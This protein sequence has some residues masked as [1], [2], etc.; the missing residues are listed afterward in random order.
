[1]DEGAGA[2]SIRATLLGKLNDGMVAVV[3]ITLDSGNG[4]FLVDG[5]LPLF[6]ADFL[7]DLAADIIG[8]DFHDQLV[9]LR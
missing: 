6:E 7:G 1:M 4:V 8:L 2:D 5:V 9:A 3:E